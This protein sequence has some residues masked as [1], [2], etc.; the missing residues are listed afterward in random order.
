KDVK[1]APWWLVAPQ[2]VLVAAILLFSLFPQYLVQPISNAVA[3]Y[4]A[5]S[6]H[7]VG[8]QVTT[9]MGHWNG[10]LIM[11]IVG[12]V[13]LF[14][15]AWMLL[16]R[17]RVQRVKQFNI[18]FAAERPFTPETTHVAYNFYPYIEK[19]MGGLVRPRATR[20]WDS[21][22]EWAHSLAAALRSIYTGHAQTYAQFIVLYLVLM[23]FLMGGA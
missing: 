12:A 15:L 21:L 13:F 8:N 4:Y 23:A 18:A 1:E 14:P 19:S 22:S 17:T 7:W 2:L 5:S 11:N 20:F 3:P 9:A 10:F 6:L 16:S